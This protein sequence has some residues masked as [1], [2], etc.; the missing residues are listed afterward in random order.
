MVW[1]GAAFFAYAAVSALVVQ[2]ILLPYVFPAWHEGHGLLKNGD[3]L[4]FHRL[5]VECADRIGREGWSAWELRPRGQAPSGIACALYVLVSPEPWTLIP[6]NAALHAAAGLAL[7]RIFLVLTGNWRRALA[8]AM[9]LVLFPSAMTWV[10]Q[11]HKDGIAI[12]GSTIGLYGWISLARE[13]TQGSAQILW[14]GLW[15]LLGASIVWIVRPYHVQMGQ[16]LG[17]F[18]AGLLSVIATVGVAT[19]RA[20]WRRAAWV[21]AISWLVVLAMTPMTRAGIWYEPPRAGR[22]GA[23][24]PVEDPRESSPRTLPQSV[25]WERSGWFPAPVENKLYALALSR[26]QFRA[27]YP[28][29]GTNV[30]MHVGFRSGSE[31][32]RYLPRAVEIAFLSPFPK[33]WIGAGTAPASSVM[34]KVAGVE[35]IAVYAA[36]AFLPFA[37]WRWRARPE[38]WVA[39]LYPWGMMTILALVIPNAGA[40]H[41]IRYGY[42]MVVVGLGVAGWFAVRDRMKAGKRPG[43]SSFEPDAQEKKTD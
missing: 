17:I 23:P 39:L 19:S 8:C 14:A 15:I 18:L 29:A 4:E 2:V 21:I 43:S 34:R 22:S 41:R 10:A 7:V 26:E 5:G 31:I 16:G 11:I 37:L 24:G 1:I 30:D 3:W 6:L 25:R 13:K 36:L 38:A 12:A 35:M 28:G 40:L 33:D 42:M 20:P 32:L 9:P 27:K